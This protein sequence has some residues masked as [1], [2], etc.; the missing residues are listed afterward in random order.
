MCSCGNVVGPNC[1]SSYECVASRLD[2]HVI[3]NKV[4]SKQTHVI[5]NKVWSKQT[6]HS[7][8]KE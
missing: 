4:W 7:R 3:K 2:T 8:N 6:R 5:K 1:H